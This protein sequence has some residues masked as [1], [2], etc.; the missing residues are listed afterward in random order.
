METQQAMSKTNIQ[1]TVAVTAAVNT[2]MC[3]SLCQLI[4]LNSGCL[5]S[6]KK[7]D[8]LNTYIV[9]NVSPKTVVTIFEL[10]LNA[11][12]FDKNVHR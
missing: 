2:T 1:L 3:M 10:L 6:S 7:T 8:T 12:A 9:I 5:F 4:P 11:P